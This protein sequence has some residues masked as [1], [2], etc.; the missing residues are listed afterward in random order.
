[1]PKKSVNPAGP[2]RKESH[3]ELLQEK[4]IDN[5]VQLQRVH[6]NL[7]EKID[8]LSTQI[9]ELLAL[10]EKAAK[11][12]AENPTSASHQSSEKDKEFLDKI[13]TL[14]DQNKTI[15]KGLTLMEERIRERISDED[16]QEAKQEEVLPMTS[17]PLPKF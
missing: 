10:F 17:R 13:N 3:H 4:L 15:A 2:G 16:N 14:M 9:S 12:F 5:F 6:I 11:T 7:A 1:M 8:R